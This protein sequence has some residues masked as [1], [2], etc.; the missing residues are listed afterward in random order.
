[1]KLLAVLKAHQVK[2]VTA[3]FV[4]IFLM[5]YLAPSIF[6]YVY[7]G[8]AGVLFDSLSDEPLSDR[9]YKDGLYVIAPWNKMYIY[10]I[11]T[12]KLTMDA[13]ALTGNGL[14]VNLGISVLFQPDSSQLATLV[15]NFGPDYIDKI[16]VPTIRTAVRHVVGSHTPEELYTSARGDLHKMVL[17]RARERFADLPFMVKDVIIE[18]I[19]MPEAI[20]ASIEKK[21]QIQQDALSYE[22]VLAKQQDEARRMK[23]EAEAIK[24]YQEI[25]GSNLTPEL[26]KWLQIRALHDLANSQ[27]S[28][29]IV[30]GDPEQLPLV[31]DGRN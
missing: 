17:D 8:Q 1:M 31:L 20:N 26:L 2:I 27:N 15:A 18:K 7:P 6:V 5:L 19:Q 12:Q 25:V 30:I 21:L 3:L 9:V 24:T 14:Q 22:F 13:G 11:T 29:V 10:D 28:K 16:V 23:I 4:F